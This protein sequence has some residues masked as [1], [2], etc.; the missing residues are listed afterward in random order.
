MMHVV[1]ATHVVVRVPE[2]VA[3][4]DV[5]HRLLYEPWVSMCCLH[6]CGVRCVLRVATPDDVNAAYLSIPL[7]EAQA[8]PC[9]DVA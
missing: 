7:R 1:R 5:V 4:R 2:L 9:Q 8:R 3:H 6:L